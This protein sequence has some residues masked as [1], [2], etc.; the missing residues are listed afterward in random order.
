M[1][2]ALEWRGSWADHARHSVQ[3]FVSPAFFNTRPEQVA[4]IERLLG[5][6]TR[7]PACYSRQNEAC[8]SHDT[9]G[10][11]A[12]ITQP[13][14]VMAGGADPICS[15]AA[16]RILSEGLPNAR[17][18]MFEDASHF[19]LMEQPERFNRLLLDWLQRHAA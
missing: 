8:Q 2:E 16:T 17:T 4:T 7:L 1:R 19:F 9:S 10:E 13:A 3:N 11:L 12:R 18:E 14:L 15:P 6:E 5:G